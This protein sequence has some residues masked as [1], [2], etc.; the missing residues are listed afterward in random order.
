MYSIALT[1]AYSLF[2]LSEWTLV[3]LEAGFD[4]VSIFDFGQFEFHVV[5]KP[6]IE[7]EESGANPFPILWCSMIDLLLLENLIHFE[8]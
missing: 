4:V 7:N 5:E 6:K 1:L 3:F 2:A 8:S